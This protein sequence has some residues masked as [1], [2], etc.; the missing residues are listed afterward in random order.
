MPHELALHLDQLYLKVIQL[1]HNPRAEIILEG[2]KL[3]GKVD[4][5]HGSILLLRAERTGQRFFI[6][7]DWFASQIDS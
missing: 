5:L 3:L 4:Y 6:L 7:L 2:G 1:T